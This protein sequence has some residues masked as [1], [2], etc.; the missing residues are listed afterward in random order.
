MLM[1]WRTSSHEVKWP[2][3]CSA[4]PGGKG[5]NRLMTY[6]EYRD[7]I[8]MVLEGNQEPYA[9]LAKARASHH[10]GDYS[11]FIS[12]EHKTICWQVP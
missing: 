7:M 9:W 8:F 11:N 10:T 2:A 1:A 5:E 6:T 4:L 12:D 3:R